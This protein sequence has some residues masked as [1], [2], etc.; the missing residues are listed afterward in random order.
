MTD[1]EVLLSVDQ[2]H[3]PEDADVFLGHDRDLA[4]RRRCALL[5]ATLAIGASICVLLGVGRL[6][7]ILPVIGA[8]ILGIMLTPTVPSEPSPRPMRQVIVVTRTAIVMRE[9]LPR[10]KIPCGEEVDLNSLPSVA[11]ISTESF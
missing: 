4:S 5:R 9:A 3:Y 10:E 8:G 7:G 1:V 6:W 2:G 11:S